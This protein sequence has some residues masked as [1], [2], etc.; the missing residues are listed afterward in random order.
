MLVR[1]LFIPRKELILIFKIIFAGFTFLIENEQIIDKWKGRCRK[2]EAFK[3]ASKASNWI[4]YFKEKQTLPISG[5]NTG[6]EQR[7]LVTCEDSCDNVK[8]KLV[9]D[10]GDPE[11][12]VLDHSQ[13]SFSGFNCYGESCCESRGGASESC[14]ISTNLDSF[15]V[16]VYAYSTYGTGNITFENVLT[17]E[18]YGKYKKLI[19]N[20]LVYI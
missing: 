18:P 19:T 11:L 17:A 3:A 5:R 20:I 1:K 7:F 13:P 8:I 2:I 9:V 16:L 12:L 15:H 10:T 6:E 14:S 4:L